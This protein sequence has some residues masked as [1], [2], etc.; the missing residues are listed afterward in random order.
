MIKSWF[1]LQTCAIQT[2]ELVSS[3]QGELNA[4]AYRQTSLKRREFKNHLVLIGYITF[5]PNFFSKSRRFQKPTTLNL[6][7][8]VS[9]H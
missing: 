3:I 7:E 9:K 5:K 1:I 6:A 2:Q 4:Q 8:I